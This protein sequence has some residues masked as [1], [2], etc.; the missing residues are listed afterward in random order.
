M[1]GWDWKFDSEKRR[2]RAIALRPKT[3]IPEW[4][5]RFDPK[6]VLGTP[7]PVDPRLSPDEAYHPE[8]GSPLLLAQGWTWEFDSRTE[9]LIPSISDEPSR[10][11][12]SRFALFAST[13]MTRKDVTTISTNT[14][15]SVASLNAASRSGQRS[16]LNP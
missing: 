9:R 3:P 6:H 7:V 13:R 5:L 8:Y 10:Y 1:P 12:E 4:T 11:P 16:S 14:T 2:Y 15:P